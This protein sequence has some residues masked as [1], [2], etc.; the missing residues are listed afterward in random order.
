MGSSE[1][2]LAIHLTCGMRIA[3]SI[4]E[5]VNCEKGSNGP[6]IPIYGLEGPWQS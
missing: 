6:E 1:R 3:G 5:R 4:P 2:G